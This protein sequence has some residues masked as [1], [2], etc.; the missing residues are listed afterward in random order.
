MRNEENNENEGRNN[1]RSFD[2]NRERGERGERGMKIRS[3]YFLPKPI[4][5]GD[6]IEVEIEAIASQGD[7]IAKKDGFVIFVKGA[8]NGEKLKIRITEVKARFGIG[9]IV[10]E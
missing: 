2:N 10:K 4:K 7:G 5:P 9:E 3:N 8:K 1:R 6:I